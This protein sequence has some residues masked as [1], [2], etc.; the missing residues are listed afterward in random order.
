ML[1]ELLK[2]CRIKPVVNQVE[3][4]P[5]LPQEELLEFCNKNGIALT[6]YCPL[7]NP[8][9]GKGSAINH[10]TVSHPSIWIQYLSW[11]IWRY[12][13][14]VGYWDRWKVQKDTWSSAP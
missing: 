9:K 8:G 13:G 5:L 6:A 11:L 1:E 14:A 10:P 12:G 7:S 4:H 3:I 2:N